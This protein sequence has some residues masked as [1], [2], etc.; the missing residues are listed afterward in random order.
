MWQ[1]LKMQSLKGKRV[2]LIGGAGF[3]GHH[4]ALAL[5]QAGVEVHVIDSLQI[6]NLLTFSSAAHD[7]YNRDLYLRFLHNRLELMREAGIPLHVQDAREYHL[8]THQLNNIKP[9]VIVHLAAVAHAGASNKDPYSTFD[10]SLRTLENALDYSRNGRVEQFVY[11]S[12]SMVYGNFPTG[13]ITEETLCEPLGIYGALKFAGEKLVIAYNQ[14]FDLPYTIVR[15]SAL[16]G[17]RCVSRRVVQV[18]IES[19]L[20]GEDLVIEGD[21][22][23]T[24]DFT[25]IDDL[26]AGIG[27]VL[28]RQEARN[29]IFNLTYG[30][31]RSIL[32]LAEMVQGYFPGLQV[33]TSERDRLIPKRG[34]LSVERAQ[35]L[36]GYS[37]QYSLEKGLAA[38]VDWYT[39]VASARPR[40]QAEKAA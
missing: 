38:Y 12:S 19:A 39:S 3:I 23:D 40:A 10:H 29:I 5:S 14:V 34:T 21:G 4:L 18:F 22:S 25:Y 16:Y 27:A 2:A 37:P 7:G 8:L 32:E 6:N 35:R 9:Q 13:E 31:A 28:T 11:F 20:A 15:P 30:Q 26:T 1:Y 33:A 24:L 36:I 17:P